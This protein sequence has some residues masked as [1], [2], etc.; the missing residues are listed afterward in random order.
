VLNKAKAK[1]RPGQ[2][3][4]LNATNEFVVLRSASRR[5]RQAGRLCCPYAL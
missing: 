3:F 5:T 4:L 2:L 1:K